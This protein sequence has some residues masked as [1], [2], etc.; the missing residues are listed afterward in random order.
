MWNIPVRFQFSCGC[1]ADVRRWKQETDVGQLDTLSETSCS[2][3]LLLPPQGCCRD[4]PPLR[5]SW[6]RWCLSCSP[7]SRPSSWTLRAEEEKPHPPKPPSQSADSVTVMGNGP[8][9]EQGRWCSRWHDSVRRSDFIWIVCLTVQV[10]SGK[11]LLILFEMNLFKRQKAVLH[12]YVIFQHF[13]QH[14]VKN[15]QNNASHLNFNS[16]L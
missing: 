4:D 5:T 7:T 11:K 8:E 10:E 15:K 3:L 12:V 16:S 14:F 13:S 1:G 2:V 9:P 6:T